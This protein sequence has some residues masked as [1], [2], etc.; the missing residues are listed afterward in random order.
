MIEP[1]KSLDELVSY[2]TTLE[3]RMAE[4]E[5]ENVRLRSLTLDN[6][7]EDR[8]EFARYVS[9]ALPQTNIVSPNF[10]KRA[11]AVWGHF[12]VAQLI[13]GISFGILYLCVFGTLLG[14]AMGGFLNN[15]NK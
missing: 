11:F 10:F 2:L 15:L 3:A 1:V 9:Q 8:R 14:S 5:A 7:R 12:F 4:L 13:I 6:S